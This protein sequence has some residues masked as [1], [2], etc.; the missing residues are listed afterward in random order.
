MFNWTVNWLTITH[1][2]VVVCVVN[3]MDL[4]SYLKI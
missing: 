3:D 4:F 2:M 1:D